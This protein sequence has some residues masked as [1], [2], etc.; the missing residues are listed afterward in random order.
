MRPLVAGSFYWVIPVFDVDFTPPGFEGQPYS[1]EMYL[2]MRDHWSQKEQPARF[3]GY[4]ETGQELWTFLGQAD[5]NW[6][7]SWIGE[8]IKP[9]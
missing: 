5:D 6:P 9:L 4:S 7:V 8:E 2:A 3:R 1:E